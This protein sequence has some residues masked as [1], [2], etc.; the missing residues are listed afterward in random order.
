VS[1]LLY[2]QDRVIIEIEEALLPHSKTED[3]LMTKLDKAAIAERDAV[4]S[5]LRDASE[6]LEKALETF[7]TTLDE[8]WGAVES[9]LSAYNEVVSD[10]NAWR[11]DIAA[12]MQSYFD[13]RS[14]KWQQSEKGTGYE[15]WKQQY[16]E[17][18]QTVELEKPDPLE[19]DIE[20]AAEYLEQL[21]ETP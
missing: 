2:K 9:A 16:D 12:D 18:L 11:E 17:E 21:P 7:N 1:L 14:E 3:N 4:C 10:A 13:E 6:A 15:A 20:D 5:Q 8:A 19:L